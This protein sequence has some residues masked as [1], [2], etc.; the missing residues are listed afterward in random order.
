MT[1]PRSVLA[2]VFAL[3]TF[4]ATVAAPV[5]AA[6]GDWSKI[7]TPAGPTYRFHYVGGGANT[8]TVSGHAS[9]SITS[10]DI[11]CYAANVGGVNPV[12]LA[13]NV[14]VTSGSFSGTAHFTNLYG[15]CRLRALP[16]GSSTTDYV[17]SF[18]GPIVVSY[19]ASTE[20]DGGTLYG[21]QSASAGNDGVV[22]VTDAGQFGVYALLSVI[23]P[24]DHLGPLSNIGNFALRSG[25]ITA[26][27]TPTQS[28]IRVD[29]HNAYLPFAVK[30][31]LRGTQ[32]LTLTQSAMTLSQAYAPN[33]DATLTESAPLMRCT[34]DNTYPPTS[35]SCPAL[36]P[37]GV[38]FVRV[39]HFFR[40]GHQVS[41][42]DSFISTDGAKH[43][44]KLQYLAAV[45]PPLS[46]AP[47]FIYPKHG[48]TFRLSRPNHTLTGFG[49]GAASVLERSDFYATADD[50]AADT[51]AVT[52]S[53]PP[54]SIIVAGA[55][56]YLNGMNYSLQVPARGRGYLGFAVSERLATADVKPLAKQAERDMMAAPKITAPKNRSVVHGKKTT[57][58]GTLS[59]GANGLPTSV[60]VNGHAAKI[61]VKN[62]N[63]ATFSATFSEAFG[64]HVLKVVATDAGGNVRT[65]AVK[66]TNKP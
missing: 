63:A 58:T 65:T 6:P 56:G 62:A 26:S 10:V 52:W 38:K 48:S 45:Q 24:A 44:L 5:S 3:G 59:A 37:T 61:T 16:S 14:P 22:V 19:G 11:Y 66:I 32:A 30:D 21:Y 28:S 57:V 43:A 27:G 7:T 40:D 33:G 50:P 41:V 17:A 36:E 35:G 23:P 54:S 64:K 8:F 60:E 51:S 18:A 29:G 9:S 1:T 55:G 13:T 49:T 4:V 42:R 31:F 53:R 39:S 2:S 15:P 25:N 47:G 20:K 34:G 46:G 12:A